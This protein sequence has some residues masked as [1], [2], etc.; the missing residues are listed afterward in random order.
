[1]IGSKKEMR[2]CFS[3]LAIKCFDIPILR[4]AQEDWM[5][6]CV[7]ITKVLKNNFKLL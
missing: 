5:L 2:D 4:Q 6:C 1:M 3:L 7:Q